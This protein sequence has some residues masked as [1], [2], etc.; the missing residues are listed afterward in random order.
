MP[1]FNDKFIFYSFF[2]FN[3]PFY[4]LLIR[5]RGHCPDDFNHRYR[6][7]SNAYRYR[8][9]KCDLFLGSSNVTVF[10]VFSIAT[11]PVT[12]LHVTVNEWNRVCSVNYSYRRMDYFIIRYYYRKKK[13]ERFEL[14]YPELWLGNDNRSSNK[15]Y[16][17]NSNMNRH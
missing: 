7:N 16:S 13:L 6:R 11:R 9:P 5:V 8:Y 4:H 14:T 1:F 12:M 3:V 2:F 10:R 15:F 17:T